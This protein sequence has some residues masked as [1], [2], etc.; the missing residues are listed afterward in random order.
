ME[1]TMKQSTLIP[2]L[3]ALIAGIFALAAIASDTHDDPEFRSVTDQDI[4]W[5]D[6]QP[7][8]FGPGLKI[9]VIHGDPS[10]PDEPYTIRASFTDGY[11]IPAHI[12][13]LAENLTVLSGTFM[14]AMGVDRDDSKLVGYRPGVFL[15]NTRGHPHNG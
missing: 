4:E 14:L 8:G 9:A 6:Y 7:P 10:V 13:P 12:H 1:D 2:V 3:I 11:I 5:N 15:Y